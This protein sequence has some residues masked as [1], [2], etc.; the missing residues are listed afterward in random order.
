MLHCLKLRQSGSS[1]LKASESKKERCGLR[2]EMLK[3][4]GIP[5]ELSSALL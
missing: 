4:N 1:A 5:V 3:S 2:A